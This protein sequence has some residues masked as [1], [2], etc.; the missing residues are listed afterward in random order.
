MKRIIRF[1]IAFLLIFLTE[2]NFLL[3][4]YPEKIMQMK[5]ALTSENFDNRVTKIQ[6][7]VIKEGKE[8]F[9][10][11]GTG[12]FVNDGGEFIY[13]V[14]AGHLFKDALK[15]LIAN[16][17][18]IVFFQKFESKDGKM[19]TLSTYDLDLIDYWKRDFL[20]FNENRDIGIL[21]LR[22]F[23]KNEESPKIKLEKEEKSEDQGAKPTLTYSASINILSDNE[24]IDFKNIE[25]GEDVYFFGYPELPTLILF[26][27]SHLLNPVIRKGVISKLID[28]RRIMIEGYAS[29]GSSGSPVFI[30]REYFSLGSY[31]IE[32]RFI[33]LITNY[34][35]SKLPNSEKPQIDN[36]GLALVESVDNILET[37]EYSKESAK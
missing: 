36:A 35:P 34:F 24:I 19:Q 31:K 22:E 3:G 14:S 5:P 10:D 32:L 37:L 12:F 20:K 11:L 26:D 30:R 16:R 23:I 2:N 18:T 6:I 4:A 1:L 13:L 21:K 8:N 17:G 25:K 28:E 33:G 29:G 7:K 27:K 9:F 15:F